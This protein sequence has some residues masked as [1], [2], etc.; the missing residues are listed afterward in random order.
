MLTFAPGS[1][2]ASRDVSLAFYD[3]RDADSATV[4]GI[5]IPLAADY[6][7]PYAYLLSKLKRPARNAADTFNPE[8]A[9]GDTGYVLMEP[10]DPER[11]PLIT[12]HGLFSHPLTWVDVHN[13]LMSDPVIRKNYQIWHFNYPP[14]LPLLEAA[15]I[16]R[17][18]TEELYAFFDPD[19]DNT[20]MRS[21]V[22]FAHSMGGLISKTIIAD[23]GSKIVDQHFVVPLEELEITPEDKERVRKL[24]FF[25]SK[26]Y[27]KRVVFIAVP[28]RGSHIS[29]NY[30]GWTGQLLTS[31]PEG[32][33]AL[34]DRIR[35][36]LSPNVLTP[37]GEKAAEEK[38]NSIKNLSPNDPT[39]KG[40]A[41]LSIDADVPF[42]SIIGD[43]G[44][45][46][47]EQS[48]DGVVAY[49]S[50]HLEGA[51]S[52]LIV[53]TKHNAHMHPLA[54]LELERILKLHLA[55]LGRDS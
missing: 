13:D 55:E 21:T 31:T 43:Q 45:G 27:V 50:S 51:Q 8:A 11:I 5:T 54:V 16:F 47:G 9:L 49:K 38:D 41:E 53:P 6:T 18:K 4:E 10:F 26:P 52:E 7:A 17:Q 24:L 34:M 1:E 20:A 19:G 29:D 30:I 15:R 12:I 39:I 22:V 3:S 44:T 33:A 40:L 32:Y 36:R 2:Q 46:D 25:E 14:G 48:S 35:G 37:E 42:H 23:S 28:H